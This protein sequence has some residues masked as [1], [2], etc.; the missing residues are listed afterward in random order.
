[1]SYKFNGQKMIMPINN[2]IITA[3]FKNAEYKKQFG[4]THY[5]S[6][7]APL[8]GDKNIWGSANGVVK[9]CGSDNVLGNVIAV[10][11]KGVDIHYGPKKGK[12]DVIVRYFHLASINVKVGQN[13][14]TSTKLG[15]V[16]NTGK[17]STGTHLHCEIDYDVT[18]P[19][20][21]PTLSGN[22]NVFKHGTDTTINPMD[23]FVVDDGGKCGSKQVFKCD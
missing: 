22:S 1:M 15:I 9:A 4:S 21:T 8:N 7:F 16:G 23:C 19:T 12:R 2:S 10:L 13:V 18:Y 20:Y 3:G 17:Y 11:Y 14:T 5:G 6:D